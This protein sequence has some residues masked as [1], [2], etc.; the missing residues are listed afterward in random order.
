MEDM[1]LSTSMTVPKYRR[2][3][4]NKN[5]EGIA[6]FILERFTERYVRPLRGDSKNKHGFCTMAVSCLM[7]EALE[8]FRQG[9]QDTKPRGKSEEAFRFFFQ[10][11]C[12]QGAGLGVFAAHADD[13]WRSIRCGILH[14][15]ETTKGWRIWRS[16][17]LFDRKRKTINATSFHNELEKAL[18]RY[19]HELKQSDWDS[20]VWR[21]L[22]KK[23][24]AVIKN[25]RLPSA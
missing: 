7:I 12:K 11:C 13:F 5:R 19:C 6:D 2:F 24:K 3:E 20:E 8:S 14:Q 18:E 17:C 1:L 15:A 21:N 4:E 10:R 22:R 9:W 23:M 16:G 25:C